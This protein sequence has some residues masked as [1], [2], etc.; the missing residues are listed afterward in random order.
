MNYKDIAKRIIDLKNADLTLRN[1]LIQDGKLSEGY[2]EEMKKLHNQ[3]AKTLDEIIDLIGYPTIDK[4]GKEA[5]EATWLIIQH[6]IEQPEFMKK[7][8][9]ILEKAVNEKKASQISLAYLTDR[10]AVF[11]N[12]PQHYGTQFDWDK[13]GELSPYPFD[14]LSKVNQRRK[15]LGLNT[16]DEQIQIMRAQAKNENESAPTDFEK[17]KQ[18]IEHWK[19]TVGW[20]Q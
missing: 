1:K 20:I 15:A 5:N 8:Q 16:L 17:R 13:N 3:N 19:K 12:K 11:E 4:V 10:I 6:S 9:I 2:N 14:S 18:E 7:C